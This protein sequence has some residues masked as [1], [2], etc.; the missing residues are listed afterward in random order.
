MTE[1]FYAILIIGSIGLIF[2]IILS[3]A[4]Q[5]LKVEEDYRIADVEALLPGYN[6]GACGTPS[7]N[8]FATEIV[9]GKGERLSR[10]KPGKV[11]KNFNP[12]LEYLKN[13]PN[14]DGTQVPI[15]L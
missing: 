7:C 6:C 15:K 11:D 8:G 10:C 14:P 5:Y 4:N 2:G 1:V 12:I 3:L 13:N 9:G